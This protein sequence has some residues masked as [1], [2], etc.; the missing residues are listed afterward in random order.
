[1]V[2]GTL[3]SLNRMKQ[4]TTLPELVDG[5]NHPISLAVAG[6][7]LCNVWVIARLSANLHTST[8]T[9]TEH[10]YAVTTHG[11]AHGT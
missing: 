4:A 6:I 9:V 5:S 2:S 1:M 3:R 7:Y 11:D 8:S 10:T